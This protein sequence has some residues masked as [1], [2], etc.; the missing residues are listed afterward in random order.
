MTA[1]SGRK[2]TWHGRELYVACT[3]RPAPQDGSLLLCLHGAYCNRGDFSWIAECEALNR[4]GVLAVDLPGHGGSTKMSA[5]AEEDFPSKLEEMAEVVWGLLGAMELQ[6][7]GR[8]L[9]VGHSLGGSVGLL[10]AARYLRP[11]QLQAFVS[12]EGCLVATDT[13]PNGLAARWMRRD[14]Q[15][16]SAQD[17]LEDI[18]AAQHL[19]RDPAGMKHWREAAEECGPTV[20]LLAVRMSRSLVDWAQSGELPRYVDDLPSFHYVYGTASGKFSSAL[21]E[22]LKGRRNCRLHG[23][24]PRGH[25]LLLDGVEA[26]LGILVGAV[27]EAEAVAEAAAGEV[28]AEEAPASKVPRLA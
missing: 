14:P 7:A 2:V 20:H 28:A 27:A 25:F 13:P 19:G 15:T 10:L 24:C 18:T 1:E 26:I 5:G 17:L 4:C 9:V 16:S 3:Y 23:I 8:V 12:L 22:A 11:P 21:S 6:R